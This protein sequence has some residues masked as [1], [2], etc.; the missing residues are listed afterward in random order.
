MTPWK[1]IRRVHSH[2]MPFVFWLV[3]GTAAFG[4]GTLVHLV[5]TS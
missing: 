2:G 3:V 1:Y 5:A 4:I